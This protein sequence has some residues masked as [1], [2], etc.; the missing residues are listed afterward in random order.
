MDWRY[1]LG[2]TEGVLLGLMIAAGIAAVRG[3]RVL[4]PDR[5][6]VVRARLWGQGVLVLAASVGIPSLFL[7][8]LGPGALY[9]AI[10]FAGAAGLLAGGALMLRARH[11]RRRGAGSA[12]TSR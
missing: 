2:L 1:A 12:R 11:D 7:A 5:R 9:F 3:G 4:G 6:R 8:L 10:S